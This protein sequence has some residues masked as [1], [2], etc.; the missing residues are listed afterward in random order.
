MSVAA[1][2]A[3]KFTTDIAWSAAALVTFSVSGLAWAIL[4]AHGLGAAG[5]G[6]LNL[7]S[8]AVVLAGLVCAAGTNYSLPSLLGEGRSSAGELLGAAAVLGS[9]M[10]AL[11]V[12]LTVFVGAALTIQAIYAILIAAM[13]TL[14][15]VSWVKTVAS[16]L[17]AAR[18][19]FRALFASGLAGQLV[20]VG[21]GVALLVTG[22]MTV[23][24]AVGATTAGAA[25]TMVWLGVIVRRELVGDAVRTTRTG[26][27]RM[28]RSGAATIPGVLGQSLNY[29]LDLFVVAAL[30]GA[31]AVGIYGISQI[32]SEILLYPALVVGQVL[33]PRAAQ[34]SR[35]GTAAPAY[36]IVVGFTVAI[37]TLL[38]LV[39]PLLIRHV[40]GPEFSEASPGL[41]ALIPGSLALALWQ[42]A[43]HELVGRG[44]LAIMSI[45]ALA[46]VLV[47][48]LVD[49]VLVPRYNVRGAAIGASIGY[50]AT[51][52]V[53]LP[54][55]RKELGYRLRDL[56]LVRPSDARLVASEL[57]RLFAGRWA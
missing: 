23:G 55:V 53:V 37:G 24:T 17:L 21:G 14:L 56:L 48:V 51:A 5:R 43:T 33:L 34:M 46:G 29:R 27:V 36:R 3:R 41:R 49:L 22:R 11:I 10:N 6:N 45:S 54:M 20:Q 52:L 47:T 42:L 44:R 16:S 50:L 1:P 13:L 18:R 25:V 40:F 2:P 35:E 12:V 15:P 57:N 9:V 31:E 7:V 38:F 39:S 8:L 19:D 30:S 26:V 32:V 4:T 28:A